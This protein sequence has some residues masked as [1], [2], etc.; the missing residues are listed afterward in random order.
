MCNYY[1]G[2]CHDKNFLISCECGKCKQVITKIDRKGR[3]RR[4]VIGHNNFGKKPWNYK[5]GHANH[6]AGYN[7]IVVNGKHVLEHR[8]IMEQHL[9]RNLEQWELVHHIDRN[10]KNNNISNLELQKG[11]KEHIRHHIKNMV[12]NRIKS[13]R[14]RVYKEMRKCMMCNVPL[15]HEIEHCTNPVSKKKGEWC[16]YKCW[17]RLHRLSFYM[18][19]LLLSE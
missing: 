7:T 13:N 19:P 3:Q 8:V 12:N 10:K 17:H 4:F 9:G 16:C 2:R 5:G 1:C 15:T 14:D 6:S 11:G 18:N